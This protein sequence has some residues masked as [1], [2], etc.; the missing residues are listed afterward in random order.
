VIARSLNATTDDPI[1]ASALRHDDG[2][3]VAVPADDI[4]AVLVDDDDSETLLETFLEEDF[5]E[6]EIVGEPEPD[7]GAGEEPKPAHSPSTA[8]AGPHLGPG[9]TPG[10]SLRRWMGAVAHEV[11]NPLATIRTFAE[12][13]PEQHHDPEF[14]ENFAELVGR[15]VGRIEAAL[16][17][18]SDLATLEPPEIAPVDVAGLLEEL[19]EHHRDTIHSRRLVVLKELDKSQPLAL[20]DVGQLRFALEGLLRKCL[21]VVPERGDVYFASRHHPGGLRGGPALRILVRFHGSSAG[22]SGAPPNPA[23]TVNA[24]EFLSAETVVRAQGGAF[25]IQIGDGEETLVV[26][27]LPAPA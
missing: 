6:I 2:A 14:R 11:R 7:S 20:G 25:T 22:H 9:E 27:D 26:I 4:G 10:V 18:I 13:F 19:L 24:I 17:E 12:L 8:V 3:F 1:P 5:D 15:G 21:E 23:P 16:S